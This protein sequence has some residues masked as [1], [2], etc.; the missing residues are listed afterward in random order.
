MLREIIIIYFFDFW[1][2]KTLFFCWF[3]LFLQNAQEGKP[4]CVEL[5]FLSGEWSV[6]VDSRLSLHGPWEKVPALLYLKEPFSRP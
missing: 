6:E 2:V 4:L 5:A 3:L 1:T